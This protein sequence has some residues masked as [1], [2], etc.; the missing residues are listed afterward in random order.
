MCPYETGMIRYSTHSRVML[1][2]TRFRQRVKLQI[3]DQVDGRA[4]WQHA[5]LVNWPVNE[6]VRAQIYFPILEN[7]GR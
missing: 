3:E 7:L 4:W 1:D 5:A 6:G 2:G